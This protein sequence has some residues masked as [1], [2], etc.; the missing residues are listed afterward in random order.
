MKLKMPAGARAFPPSHFRKGSGNEIRGAIA[1]SDIT[2]RTPL[3][4]IGKGYQVLQYILKN[5][6]RYKWPLS[7]R[8]KIITYRS[9]PSFDPSKQKSV[10]SPNVCRLKITSTKRQNLR[11]VEAKRPV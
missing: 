2:G 3:L 10:A 9:L 7:N 5:V 11:H 1:S 4:L 6:Y 8:A